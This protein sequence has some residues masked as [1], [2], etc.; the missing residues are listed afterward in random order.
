MRLK[1]FVAVGKTNFM[2]NQ[3]YKILS[4]AVAKCKKSIE[5][6][7][8]SFEIELLDLFWENISD[9][10]EEKLQNYFMSYGEFGGIPIVKD[11]CEELFENWSSS[12]SMENINHILNKND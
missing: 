3:E 5:K 2:T 12:L 7:F 11:N 1:L 10:N 6:S 9:K 4:E 8:E